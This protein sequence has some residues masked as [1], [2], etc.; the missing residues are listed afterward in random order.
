MSIGDQ[1]PADSNAPFV[2]DF[3]AH[4]S[5]ELALDHHLVRREPELAE[6]FYTALQ[7]CD[8]AIVERE[9]GQLGAVDASGLGDEVRAFV[10]RRFAP[11][12]RDEAVLTGVLQ[13]ILSLTR[14]PGPA[15]ETLGRAIAAAIAVVEPD[16]LWVALDRVTVPRG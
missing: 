6:R 11:R 4:V 7:D 12:Y 2:L 10:A 13:Y 14:V 3:V 8:A 1:G 15:P 9:A 16:A 5:V